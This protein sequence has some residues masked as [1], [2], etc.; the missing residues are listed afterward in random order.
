MVTLPALPDGSA[1]RSTLGIVTP[2]VATEDLLDTQGVAE[3]LGLAHRNTVHEYQQRYDD[4]P[5]PVFDLGKGRVKL[6]LRPDIQRW[7]EEQAARG[8]TRPK[9][10]TSR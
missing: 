10:R 8:R 4:M 1:W 9:R 2:K 3:I 5:K 7:A 6:W